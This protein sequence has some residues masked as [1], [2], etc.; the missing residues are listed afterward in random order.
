MGVG[1]YINHKTAMS[2]Q[3]P[4]KMDTMSKPI[5]VE[6]PEDVI[7]KIDRLIELKYYTSRADFT[8]RAV[9]EHLKNEEKYIAESE[10]KNKIERPQ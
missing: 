2:F 4:S 6:V 1:L 5:Y 7:R 9:I 3:D 10:K 8:R